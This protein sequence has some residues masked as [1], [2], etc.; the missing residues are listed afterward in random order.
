MS[1]VSCKTARSRTVSSTC[2]GYAVTITDALSDAEHEAIQ[3][4]QPRA[5]IVWRY[6]DVTG[7]S[8]DGMKIGEGALFSDGWMVTHWLPTNV[9]NEPKTETWHHKGTG[10]FLKTS[11]HEGRTVI[12]FLDE[13]PVIV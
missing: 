3:S 5:F 2:V 13:E 11:G 8:G 9:C 10:P 4:S 7:I 12:L 6:E 1:R